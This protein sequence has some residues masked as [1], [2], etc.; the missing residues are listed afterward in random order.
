MGTRGPTAGALHSLG[1]SGTYRQ[2]AGLKD[3]E[4]NQAKGKAYAKAQ[5]KRRDSWNHGKQTSSVTKGL[6]REM[7]EK[8]ARAGLSAHTP[9]SILVLAS[10]QVALMFRKP[11]LDSLSWSPRTATSSYP[12]LG[13]PR[14]NNSCER[15]EW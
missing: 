4:G 2:E 8:L 7:R 14:Q 15:S 1:G 5:D 11:C 3:G 6:E 9:V 12:H 10:P 13:W